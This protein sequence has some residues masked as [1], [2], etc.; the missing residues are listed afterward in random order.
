MI[1]ALMCFTLSASRTPPYP[2]GEKISHFS[3][4]MDF[5]MGPLGS[6]TRK[7][8]RTFSRTKP[9]G[10]CKKTIRGGRRMHDVCLREQMMRME[11]THLTW[12]TNHIAHCTCNHT[13]YSFSMSA[14]LRGSM[15][16]AITRLTPAV[17]KCCT[18][19]DPTRPK[20]CTA[21]VFP[22]RVDPSS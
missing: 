5:S 6:S 20:P 19:A 18:N 7:I 17:S 21:T 9:L 15:S 3:A 13:S 2:H 1:F 12:Q 16:E 4:R 22:S 8:V 10:T 14:T 11:S